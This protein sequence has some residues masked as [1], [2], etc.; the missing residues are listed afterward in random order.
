MLCPAV[1]LIFN[2][3]SEAWRINLGRDLTGP[4]G[5]RHLQQEGISPVGWSRT[6][7]CPT[8]MEGA[9]LCQEGCGGMTLLWVHQPHS[10]REQPTLSMGLS[11]P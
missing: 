1:P 5:G 10:N 6:Q 9:A 7:C 11:F 8:V 2:A 4:Q 3:L